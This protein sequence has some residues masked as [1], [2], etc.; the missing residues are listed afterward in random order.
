VPSLKSISVADRREGVLKGGYI[1]KKESGD[2]K[3]ILMATGSEVQHAL[4]AAEQLGDGVRVVSLPCF[5][6]FERQSPEYIES[7]LPVSCS[8]RV[9]VE[10]GVS[11]SWGKYVGLAGK[12]VTIDS[13]G[14]SA[15]GDKVMEV[16]GMTADNVA[17]VA[18]ELL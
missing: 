16:F 2:L 10:A 8:K 11:T 7:V 3:L 9:A 6:R 15:P 18:K 12:T 13:F 17:S 5:E 1:A 4:G 14:L